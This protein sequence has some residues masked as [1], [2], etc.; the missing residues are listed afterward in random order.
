MLLQASSPNPY[1]MICDPG[2]CDPM[3][4]AHQFREFGTLSILLF[5]AAAFVA[6]RTFSR[7]NFV[8]PLLC[9]ALIAATMQVHSD[10]LYKWQVAVLSQLH[11]WRLTDKDH[12]S[13]E[14]TRNVLTAFNK[15]AYLNF[16]LIPFATGLILNLLR[17]RRQPSP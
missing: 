9:M 17:Q 7:T 12:Q 2:P 4:L 3:A 14:W 6:G 13:L 1:R 5:V 8:L 15:R 10:Y 16:A 11:H